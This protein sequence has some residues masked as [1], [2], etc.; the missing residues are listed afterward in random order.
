MYKNPHIRT[1]QEDRTRKIS[2]III[3]EK[4]NNKRKNKELIIAWLQVLREGILL[5]IEINEFNYL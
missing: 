3:E 4:N 1:P 2:L 5:E